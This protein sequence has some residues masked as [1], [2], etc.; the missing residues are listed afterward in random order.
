MTKILFL[1]D[2]EMILDGFRRMLRY[3]QPDWELTFHKSGLDALKDLET[4]PFDL[5][6]TDLRMPAMDGFTFLRK[7][8]ELRPDVPRIVLSAFLSMEN[9]YKVIPHAQRFLSKP[10][11]LEILASTINRLVSIRT[12]AK[13]DSVS[14]ILFGAGI[15]RTSA[16]TMNPVP[17]AGNGS[18]GERKFLEDT[19][20]HNPAWTAES[21]RFGLFTQGASAGDSV[22]LYEMLLSM[23]SQGAKALAGVKIPGIFAGGD[24]ETLGATA[25]ARHCAGTGL[26]AAEWIKKRAGSQALA[27]KAQLAGLMHDIGKLVLMSSDPDRYRKVL[28]LHKDQGKPLA[29]A[30]AAIFEV[31]HPVIGANILSV[32]GVP[33]DITIAV[34]DH[35]LDPGEWQA[36]PGDA[37]LIREAVYHANRNE[38]EKA[39]QA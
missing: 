10:T 17:G 28:A 26:L 16:T 30:E 39:G 6:V 12:Q 11:R 35:H 19:L 2:D 21:L 4:V 14:R 3:L 22:L 18:N 38:H 23:G 7:A 32:W 13:P 27:W 8:R 31:P 33:D 36:Q 34:R 15:L 5:L 29:E 24:D 25:L 20:M 1:D 9:I 37:G